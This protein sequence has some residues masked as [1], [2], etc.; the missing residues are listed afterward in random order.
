MAAQD[1]FICNGFPTALCIVEGGPAD[2]SG[3][4]CVEKVAGAPV[5]ESN[6]AYRL[7]CSETLASGRCHH[8]RVEVLGA[9]VWGTLCELGVDYIRA[10]EVICTNLGRYVGTIYHPPQSITRR[11]VMR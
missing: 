1:D 7:A 4:A 5:D 9:G 2:I 10:A 8:G 3:Y 6:V 11:R